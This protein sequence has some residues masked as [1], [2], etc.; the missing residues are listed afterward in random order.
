MFQ[1]IL[2]VA[3]GGGIGAVLR[4]LISLGGQRLPIRF[5]LTTLLTNFLGCCLI[6]FLSGLFTGIW[7]NRKGLQ[8]FLVTGLCGGFTTFSTFG[9]ETYQLFETGHPVL[10]GCNLFFSVAGCLAGV[11]LGRTL[12]GRIS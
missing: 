3:A 7:S 8:L 2:L 4:Y 1:S 9:L 5:P 12:S 10:A 11:W 6:G